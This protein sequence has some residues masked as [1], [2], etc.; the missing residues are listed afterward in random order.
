V[1]AAQAVE[2]LLAGP[3][4]PAGAVVGIRAPGERDEIFA[5]GRADLAGTAVSGETAF[6][7]ASVTKVAATT[8]ALLAL[9]SRGA[10]G[11]DDAV[12]RFVPHARATT[13]RQLLLHRAGLWEWQPL[14]LDG[15]DPVAAADALP[16]RY[17]IDEGRHYSD[18][19]FMLL[20]RIVAAVAGLPLDQAIRD[21]VTDPLGLRCTGFGPAAAPVAASALGDAA[22]RRMVATGEPYPVLSPSRDFAWRENEIL[23]E[24]NDGNC[25]HAF[26]GVSGHAGLFSTAD[27]LLTLGAAL[28]DAE[29]HTDLW[30]PDVVTELFRDGPDP[31]QALGWRSRA[32]D[33][34]GRRMRMLW[35]PGFTGCALG[36]IPE[37]RTSV[38]MLTNRL[39]AAHPAPTET[40]WR[41]ALRTL[42]GDQ[43]TLDPEGTRTP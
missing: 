12:S 31:G 27:D 40:L 30:R 32:V 8:T 23:G 17:A 25:F 38:V 18:L 29:Q 22:E 43:P 3:S 33:V 13:I 42:L 10:L 6:D 7:V 1:S 11:F 9:A 37:A 28:A 4:A 5:A 19:G 26:G 20:G 35:H 41:S 21:L 36:L 16:P 39:L 15:G 14:Y 24:A 34:D 2:Q